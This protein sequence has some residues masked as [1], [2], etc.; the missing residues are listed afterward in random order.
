[1]KSVKRKRSTLCGSFHWYDNAVVIASNNLK[2]QV[3]SLQIFGS[4]QSYSQSN[5]CLQHVKDPSDRPANLPTDLIVFSKHC[6]DNLSI[7]WTDSNKPLSSFFRK[8]D[9]YFCRLAPLVNKYQVRSFS[10][11]TLVDPVR[12]KRQR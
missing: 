6:L 5:D 4:I 10:G 12:Q 3:P 2:I 1:M 7:T 9:P 8:Y 11:N